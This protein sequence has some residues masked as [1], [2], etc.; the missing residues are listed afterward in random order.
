VQEVEAAAYGH[1]QR[2]LR[3]E[4]RLEAARCALKRQ[5]AEQLAALQVGHRCPAGT[6]RRVGASGMK[7]Q[8]RQC[9]LGATAAARSPAAQVLRQ[10]VEA[11]EQVMAAC[12]AR[13]GAR[14]SEALAALAAAQQVAQREAAAGL[15]QERALLEAECARLEEEQR[16]VADMKQVRRRTCAC[17]ARRTGPFG[18]WQP[19]AETKC[20]PPPPQRAAGALA[21]QAA[22]EA[23]LRQA[24][25][26]R[27]EAEARAAGLAAGAQVLQPQLAAALAEAA[28]LQ[29]ALGKCGAMSSQAA[30]ALLRDAAGGARVRPLL[31]AAAAASLQGQPLTS[32]PAPRACSGWC[33][34]QVPWGWP[35]Q[36]RAARVR[37]AQLPW[38]WSVSGS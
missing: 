22:G 33:N 13:A 23:R 26:A 31:L 11:R 9:A 3:E 21:S 35:R 16:R 20:A 6:A 1:R 38:C 15:V 24:E 34:T 28:V 8:L 12:E 30:E 7:R 2:I 14:V 32:R 4:E 5:E 25:S 10:A 18:S 29:R 17:H 37:T 27:C 19:V 36:Q